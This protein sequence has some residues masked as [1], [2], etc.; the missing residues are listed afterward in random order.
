MLFYGNGGPGPH[1]KLVRI[2]A[3]GS[4]DLDA[5]RIAKAERWTVRCGWIPYPHAQLD[6]IWEGE[7]FMIDASDVPEAQAQMADQ[8]GRYVSSTPPGDEWYLFVAIIDGHGAEHFMTLQDA[9]DWTEALEAPTG[10]IALIGTGIEE[11]LMQIR[12]EGGAISDATVNS[13]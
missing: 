8:Y 2:H 9:M 1:T 6:M 13:D 7:L 5:W 12:Y 3:D 11:P 4:G 10:T